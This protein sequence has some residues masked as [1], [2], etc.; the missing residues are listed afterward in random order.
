MLFVTSYSRQNRE[1]K[2]RLLSCGNGLGH[3]S[4]L[5]TRRNVDTLQ[6]AWRNLEF[7]AV[8][9]P[10]S[11]L[12]R[13]RVFLCARERFTSP[14]HA[15]LHSA[16]RR[17]QEKEVQKYDRPSRCNYRYR[18][19]NGN[20]SPPAPSLVPP[21]LPPSHLR[22]SSHASRA[23]SSDRSAKTQTGRFVV[24]N[25][26]LDPRRSIAARSAVRERSLSLYGRRIFPP[27]LIYPSSFSGYRVQLLH[28][29]F[30]GPTIGRAGP[31]I[32]SFHFTP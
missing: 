3:R 15:W 26:P 9:A 6:I 1:R 27:L 20:K 32:R 4:L 5:S 24:I 30:K 28:G 23:I 10:V 17:K 22:L 25:H 8:D 11:S 2:L 14:P 21:R 7:P 18:R 31:A 16:K 13:S 19:F 29:P 12:L